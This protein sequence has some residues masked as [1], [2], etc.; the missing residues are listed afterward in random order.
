M[1]DDLPPDEREVRA[2][3]LAVFFELLDRN[4]EVADLRRI[5]PHRRTEYLRRLGVRQ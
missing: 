1:N 4:Q 5:P 2:E 3:Q